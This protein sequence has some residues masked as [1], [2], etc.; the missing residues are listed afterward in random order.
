[1]TAC[2]A[3]RGGTHVD[4][5]Q[6]EGPG[7]AFISTLDLASGSINAIPIGAEP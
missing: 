7:P 4:V 6:P 3:V 1:M 5:F 2:L